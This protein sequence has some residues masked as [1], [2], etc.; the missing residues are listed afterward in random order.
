MV[1]IDVMNICD[2]FLIICCFCS[3]VLIDKNYLI[4]VY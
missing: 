4:N 3:Y 1:G 2:L